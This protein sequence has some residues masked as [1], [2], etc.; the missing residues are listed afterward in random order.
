M[1]SRSTD[2][3]HQRSVE[4][5]I[6]FPAN[7]AFC[8]PFRTLFAYACIVCYAACVYHKYPRVNLCVGVCGCVHVY[9]A[10]SVMV[11]VY[12]ALSLMT[13]DN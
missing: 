10:L 1:G 5:A 8:F 4:T 13:N 12:S 2:S 7:L 6:D 9:S 3:T 11:H